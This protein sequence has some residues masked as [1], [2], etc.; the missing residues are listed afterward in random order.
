MVVQKYNQDAFGQLIRKAI[1]S[2]IILTLILIL[3]SGSFYTVPA[4]SRGVLLTFG[5]ADMDAKGEGLHMKIPLI[6]KVVRMNVKTQIYEADASAAS[7]DLQI[8]TAKMATNFHII[9]EKAP[10]IFTNL[11]IT[12]A[13]TV[14]MP[15][16]QEIVKSITAQFTAEELITKREQVRLQIKEMFK[17]RLLERN[18][19][20]EEI[21]IIDFDFSDVFNAA[22]EAKAAQVQASLTASNKLSQIEFEAKQVAAKAEGEKKA[23]IASAEGDAEAI[24]I[25][26]EQLSKSPQYIEYLKVSRWD[27]SL[28]KVTGSTVPFINIGQEA[29]GVK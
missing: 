10:A 11:G 12:Y 5:K 18:I 29:S 16:E 3:I 28:P 4:G 8:V 14:I 9:P 23:K 22:I 7:K 19:I 25:V 2:I 1:V 26:N 6:Q 13:E 17:E 20:V 21:S 27:G 15:M 24:R